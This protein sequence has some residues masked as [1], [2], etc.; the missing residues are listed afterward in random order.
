MSAVYQEMLA[1]IEA[2]NM[3]IVWNAYEEYLLDEL[4]ESDPDKFVL[5]IMIQV[6]PHP[7]G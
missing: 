1:F 2:N 6:A 5:K 4:A 7:E 3:K